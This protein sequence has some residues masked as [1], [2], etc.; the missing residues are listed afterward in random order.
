M[1]NI[2]TIERTGELKFSPIQINEDYRKKWNINNHDFFLLTMDGEPISDT[3]YR[4]GAIGGN[5]K[6]NYFML[7][8]HVEAYYEDNITKDEARKPHLE[9][10]W[11]ILNR[12]GIEK[13]NFKQFATPYIV[14][15]SCI[16]SLGNNYYNIET[17]Y[18]YCKSYT[19]MVSSEYVFL[20]NDYDDDKSRRGVMKIKKVDGTW[21]LFK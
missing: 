6:D 7:L 5:P 2:Q 17:G 9:S 15:N 10:Q 13:V 11:C 1:S 19:V 3:L 8:K 21:E 20:S 16:Y 4:T 18:F 14:K 12:N